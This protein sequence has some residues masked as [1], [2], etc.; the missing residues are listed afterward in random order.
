VPFREI[1]GLRFEFVSIRVHRGKN[2]KPHRRPAV[3][4]D[5]SREQIKTQPRHS[6]AAHSQ[7][8]GSDYDSQSE[9][10]KRPTKPS[11]YFYDDEI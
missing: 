8:A 3:G 7:A 6:A 4:F 1:R 10:S 11:N 9:R 2:K 5:K